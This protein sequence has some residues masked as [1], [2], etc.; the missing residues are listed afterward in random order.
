MR[1]DRVRALVDIG[2]T[3]A[4]SA[5]ADIV[6]A[7]RAGAIAGGMLARQARTMLDQLEAVDHGV[8][9]EAFLDE[10]QGLVEAVPG[11]RIPRPDRRRRAA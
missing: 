10:L 11:I 4:L 1:R 8:A 3:T 5:M 9:I 7:K 2:T 6:S